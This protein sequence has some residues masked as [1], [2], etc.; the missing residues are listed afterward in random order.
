MVHFIL[1]YESVVRINYSI[2]FII[3]T[4]FYAYVLY[5]FPTKYEREFEQTDIIVII[6]L[7]YSSKITKD[8]QRPTLS[9]PST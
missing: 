4:H 5:F 2:I 6:Y 8:G 1:I 9:Y 7:V 3:F